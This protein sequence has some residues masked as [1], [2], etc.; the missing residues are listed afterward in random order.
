MGKSQK[1]KR[2]NIK[3]IP[4]PE[5]EENKRCITSFKIYFLKSLKYGRKMNQFY[6]KTVRE[7]ILIKFHLV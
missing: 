6:G 3:I 5:V 1:R 2:F 7:N 4:K